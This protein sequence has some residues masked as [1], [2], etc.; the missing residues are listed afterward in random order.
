MKNQKTSPKELME[1]TDLGN[2]TMTTQQNYSVDTCAS[3]ATPEQV[4]SETTKMLGKSPLNLK[5]EIVKDIIVC[6][7]NVE[8]LKTLPDGSIDIVVTSPPYD[9]LRNYNGYTMDLHS[10]G[11]QLYRV[12]KPGGIAAVVI[13]DSTLDGH[14]TLTS[15]RMIVDW[16][17]D[18]GFGLFENCIYRRQGVEGAWWTKRFRVDHEYLPIFIKGKRPA[19][20]NKETLKIPS[21]HGGKTMTGAAVRKKDGTQEKSRQVYINPM[22]CRGTVWD[23]NQCGDGSKLKHIHPATF[24]NTL[25]LD[26]I[27]CF[28]PVGGIV[29]DPFVGSGTTC[30]AAKS[31][32]RHYIGIDVSNEYCDIAKKRLETEN[33]KRNNTGVTT[34]KS[35]KFLDFGN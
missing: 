3:N 33:I 22:K 12:L 14:K 20:F 29:L 10:V 18:I 21:K 11:E 32:N 13:Q 26:I 4:L 16:C 5:T 34:E 25:P 9:G 35:V 7:D 31:T 15:F 27:E 19:Y 17:D 30:V 28:C 1:Q 23:Y 24:P 6:K 8:Y 2:V